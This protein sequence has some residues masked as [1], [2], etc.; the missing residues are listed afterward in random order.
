MAGEKSK[1]GSQ[2]HNGFGAGKCQYITLHRSREE[3]W[4]S[5]S[6]KESHPSVWAGKLHHSDLHFEGPLGCPVET[7]DKAEAV[8][9]F[10][11]LLGQ[12]KQEVTVAW[13]SSEGF[14]FRVYFENREDSICWL[15]G[16]GRWKTEKTQQW[17]QG[18][19]LEQRKI[20]TA[21]LIWAILLE[22][23]VWK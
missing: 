20:G 1:R 11:R 21:L 7:G 2:R 15:I 9:Q 5:L 13:S 23:Q 6:G 16:P 3:L 17:L 19:Q 12:S 14:G 10:R 22:E 8:W 18:L 4:L